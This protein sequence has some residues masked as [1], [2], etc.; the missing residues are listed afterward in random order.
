MSDEVR[1]AIQPFSWKRVFRQSLR[2]YF[3]PLV[4]AYKGIVREMREVDQEMHTAGSS[5]AKR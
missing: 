2:M 3:A 4:G 1:A 5:I